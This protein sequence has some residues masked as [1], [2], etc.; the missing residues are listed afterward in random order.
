LIHRYLLSCDLWPLRLWSYVL[1]LECSK[2]K[3]H[4]TSTAC[5]RVRT[6]FFNDALQQ[7]FRAVLIQLWTIWRTFHR[8]N[9]NHLRSH[10][11]LI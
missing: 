6:L 2:I 8:F 1:C 11:F 7:T 5:L 3:R 9:L 4:M 10:Q